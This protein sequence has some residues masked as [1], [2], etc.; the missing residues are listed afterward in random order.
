MG[1]DN[2]A[3]HYRAGESSSPDFIDASDKLVALRFKLI[4]LVKVGKLRQSSPFH[5]SPNPSYLKRGT[6]KKPSLSIF[7]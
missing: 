3:G 7:S 2:G 1:Q 6:F 5:N 4:F